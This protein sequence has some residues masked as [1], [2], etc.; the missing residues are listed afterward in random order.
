MRSRFDTNHINISATTNLISGIWS[1]VQMGNEYIQE[2]GKSKEVEKQK[3]SEY[4]M[5]AEET[6]KKKYK[7][8]IY[9]RTVYDRSKKQ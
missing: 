1:D 6:V 5:D 2:C 3:E 7:K 8:E 9:L 4:A